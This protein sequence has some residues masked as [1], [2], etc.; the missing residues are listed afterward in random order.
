[1][2]CRVEC[3]NLSLMT[4]ISQTS[5][6]ANRRRRGQTFRVIREDSYRDYC[7]CRFLVGCVDVERYRKGACKEAV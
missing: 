6:V 3:M 4:C 2:R 5:L 1:M 7:S